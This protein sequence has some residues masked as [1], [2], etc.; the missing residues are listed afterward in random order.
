LSPLLG[1]VGTNIRNAPEKQLKVDRVNRLMGQLEAPG[2]VIQDA[3]AGMGLEDAMTG[4]GPHTRKT[5]FGQRKFS[6]SS[7]LRI[8]KDKRSIEALGTNT[9]VDIFMG[10]KD[11]IFMFNEQNMMVTPYSITFIDNVLAS[12]PRGF[13]ETRVVETRNGPEV[14]P[15]DEGLRIWQQDGL[16]RQLAENE[17]TPI[18]QMAWN[19]FRGTFQTQRGILSKQQ[20]REVFKTLEQYESRFVKAFAAGLKQGKQRLLHALDDLMRD[21]DQLQQLMPGAEISEITSSI[22]KRQRFLTGG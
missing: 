20:E 22:R 9:A 10:N 12:N 19:D 11:R 3:A 17:F 14:V 1:T 16:T 21:P 13:F 7:P 8:F 5:A 18:A 15:S 4:V 6:K 2:L